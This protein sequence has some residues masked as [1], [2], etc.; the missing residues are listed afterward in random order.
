MATATL[1]AMAICGLLFLL[2]VKILPAVDSIP[3]AGQHAGI[4]AAV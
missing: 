2:G 3:L 1:A 4:S